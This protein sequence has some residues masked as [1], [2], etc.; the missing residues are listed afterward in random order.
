MDVSTVV[1]IDVLGLPFDPHDLVISN[2]DRILC[3]FIFGDSEI[4]RNRVATTNVFNTK[5]CS[6]HFFLFVYEYMDSIQSFFSKFEDVWILQLF[7]KAKT[8]SCLSFLSYFE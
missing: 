5:I 3:I 7:F 6:L 4:C 8:N 2:I 1:T